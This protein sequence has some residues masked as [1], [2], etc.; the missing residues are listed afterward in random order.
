MTEFIRYRSGPGVSPAWTEDL[1][2]DAVR[3]GSIT[4]LAERAEHCTVG[5]SSIVIDDPDADVGHSGD[6]VLGHQVFEIDETAMAAGNRRLYQGL[7]GDPEYQHRA[8][9]SLM[10]GSAREI[11][12]SLVDLNALLSFREY[13]QTDTTASRPAETVSARLAWAL[14]H[15]TLSGIVADNGMVVASSVLLDAA[16]YHGQRPANVIGDCELATGFNAFVYADET[17]TVVPSLA[18]FDSNTS[19][20]MSSTLRLS[21][22]ST[23]IDSSITFAPSKRAR[24]HASFENVGSRVSYQY[25]K[26]TVNVRRAATELI[27]PAR[28][29]PASSSNVKTSDKA[30][31]QA[32]R[33]LWEHRI[34]EDVIYTGVELPSD[35]VNLIRAGQ[36]IQ[37]KLPH[38]KTQR[39]AQSAFSWWRITQRSVA[40]LA[41]TDQLYTVDLELSPQESA[42]VPGNCVDLY[43]GTASGTRY[44]LGSFTSDGVVYYYRSG[45]AAPLVPDA[46]YVGSWHFAELGAGGLGTIDFAGD[47]VQNNLVFMTVGNGTWTIQTERYGGTV[48]A[49]YVAKGPEYSSTTIVDT[50]NSGDSVVVTISDAVDG[51]CI[52]VVKLYDVGGPGACGSKWGWSAAAWVAA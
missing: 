28:D 20:L 4:G 42:Y 44:P 15:E 41:K 16:K 5:Q 38:L 47:C 33:M 21:T 36:R 29:L 25:S 17:Q 23:D 10:I 18:F 26:G 52:R 30:T 49:L 35:K 2:N 7:T 24:L 50:I 12:L 11:V 6:A 51:D 34:P 32:D 9:S 39:H 40:T 48:R 8:D 13:L 27:Y 1:G 37:L 3:L 22:V 19:T 14:A 45:Y 46:T 43:P 31:D